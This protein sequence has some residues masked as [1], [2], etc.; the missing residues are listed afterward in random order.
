MHVLAS[1]GERPRHSLVLGLPSGCTILSGS[2]VRDA[3]Y[4]CTSKYS[5]QGGIEFFSSSAT[6]TFCMVY[7]QCWM[8]WRCGRLSE[9]KA[10]AASA[11]TPAREQNSQKP[12]D[13]SGANIDGQHRLNNVNW[14]GSVGSVKPLETYFTHRTPGN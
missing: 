10:P 11:C 14:F 3:V 7:A 8:S 2:R 5:F 6:S 4:S 12:A 1:H 9:S 13:E